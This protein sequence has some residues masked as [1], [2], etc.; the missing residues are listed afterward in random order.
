[1]SGNRSEVEASGPPRRTSL[2]ALAPIL[3]FAWRYRGRLFGALIALV[4]A[5]AATLTTPIAIRG[6][7]DNGFTGQSADTLSQYFGLML[8]VVVVLAVAS[9]ARYYLVITFG[10]RIV[11]DLRKAVFA[12]LATLDA[13]FFDRAQTGELVSRLTADTT[14]IKSAFGATASLALRNLFL[15][16]GAVAMMI[17]TSPKLSALV[18]AAIPLIVLPLVAGGRGVRGRSRRAQDRLA[19]ASAY[20]AENLGEIRTMQAFNAEAQTRGRFSRAAEEAFEAARATTKARAVVT[21]L[22]IFLSFSSVLGVVWLGAQ[23]VIDKK[24]TGGLLSQFVLYAI[25]G[26]AA[27][28][29]L[30]EVWN[31]TSQ[32]AGAAARLAEILQTRPSIAAPE[33]AVPLPASARGDISFE[34]V[35]FRYP[36]RLHEPVLT[37]LSFA[38]RP[39]E[40]I[41]IVGPSGAGKSTIF[42]LL[43]RFYDPDSGRIRVDGVNIADMAPTDLRA[44]IANVPQDPAIFGTTIGENIRYGGFDATD[45]AVEEAARRA[46]AADFIHELP[47]GYASKVGERGVTLSGGQKQRLA[48]ARAILKDTPIL[49][50]DEATSALDAENERLVQKAIESLIGTRT[51]L[52][53]AHRL[54]TVRK[55]DRILVMENGRVVEEGNDET[56]SAN[57]GL[58]ARLKQLQF[59]DA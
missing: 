47:D 5:S 18:M 13:A 22:A 48:I 39:G 53:I 7:I 41:A 59:D 56:L 8:I 44:R 54:S 46:Q 50:L 2:R 29:Q 37:D 32:A 10:E 38:T 12:H 55:A 28:G 1:M 30:S 49:L 14:Q 3:P 52:V 27:L 43:M 26:A 36:T 6:I 45:A 35:Q 15:F 31:E 42:H 16:I 17:Y 33:K 40:T 4:I 9:A 51:I 20:A 21:F 58:Y 34:N 23:D 24:M 25:F 57:D 11:A 19:D